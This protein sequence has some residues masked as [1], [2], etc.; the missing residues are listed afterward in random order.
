MEVLNIRVTTI[1]VVEGTDNT[2][3]YV[4][5]RTTEDDPAASPTWSEWDRIDSGQVRR[6]GIRVSFAGEAA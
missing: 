5:M 1:L 3:A 2:D 4:E 6:A